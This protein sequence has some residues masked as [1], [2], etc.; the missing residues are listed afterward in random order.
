MVAAI[1]NSGPAT[2]TRIA[3]I[4]SSGVPSRPS[5]SRATASPSHR[6]HRGDTR[7]RESFLSKP[8]NVRS[9]PAQPGRSSKPHTLGAPRPS[10]GTPRYSSDRR[11]SSSAGDAGDRASDHGEEALAEG[12][13]LPVAHP[14]D[15]A[16]LLE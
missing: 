6:R 13:E 10:R 2:T 4:A 11:A 9:A 8:S 12:L 5:R 3:R 14:L 15:L 16:E 7:S 1:T